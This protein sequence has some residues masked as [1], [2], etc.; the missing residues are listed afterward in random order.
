[1]DP[2]RVH[3]VGEKGD[4]GELRYTERHYTRAEAHDGP[5]YCF[6]MLALRQHLEVLATPGG[7]GSSCEG[8]SNPSEQLRQS[9]IS[10]QCS[11][12][13]TC[14]DWRATNHRHNY[15]PVVELP[16]AHHPAAHKEAGSNEEA[17]DGLDSIACSQDPRAFVLG[18]HLWRQLA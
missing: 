9:S 18:R 2:A 12:G 6:R 5:E 10:D 1:M 14:Q 4:D 13:W 15:K 8:D 16:L 17:G 7:D 3:N 11:S